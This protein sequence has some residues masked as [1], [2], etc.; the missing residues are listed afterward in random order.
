VVQENKIVK[1]MGNAFE[2]TAI[3]SHAD[4]CKKAIEAAIME[5]QRIEL[6]LSTFREES[7]VILINNN[8]GIKPVKVSKELVDLIARAIR[9]SELT[10]GAFDIS[11]GGVD[12]RIWKF[13]TTMDS[14]PSAEEALKSVHLV[15]FRN[16][17]VDRYAETIYLLKKGMRIGF[18][19]TGKGYAAMQAKAVMRAMG[20]KSGLVNAAGDL[21]VWGAQLDGAPWNIGIA[22][23]E[24]KSGFFS[25]LQ[26]HEGSIAT[27]GDYEKYVIIDG[28]R[29]SHTIDPRTGLPV[30]GIK[31]V[32]I[33]CSNAELADALA[34]PVMVMGIE[35][36]LN[37]INQIQG[38][39][40]IIID[41]KNVLHLSKNLFKFL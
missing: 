14:L 18:G 36:G 8:A 40:A 2:F 9:I 38:V 30:H 34:T 12:K 28:K 35:V 31:S 27:S 24:K 11:Y 41:D 26:F 39:E 4:V 7:E 3:H 25:K 22:L 32:S 37:M 5:V 19:G 29:Y 15:N 17:I 20:I 33:I 10:Q 13:D 21:T 23:P 16:I 6:F 1:L